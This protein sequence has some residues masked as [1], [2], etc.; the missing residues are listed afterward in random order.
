MGVK[1][2]TRKQVKLDG[3]M[4]PFI[5]GYKL[6]NCFDGGLFWKTDLYETDSYALYQKMESK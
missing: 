5:P 2:N 6:I 4:L 1:K 3:S